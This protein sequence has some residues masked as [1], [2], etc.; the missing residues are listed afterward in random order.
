MKGIES[1][2]NYESSETAHSP[3]PRGYGGRSPPIRTYNAGQWCASDFQR[4]I[5]L[6]L[7]YRY[8]KLA[9]EANF[10]CF[11]KAR[12]ALAITHKPRITF[13]FAC[14]SLDSWKWKQNTPFRYNYNHIRD[15]CRAKN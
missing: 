9:E 13:I 12:R 3:R 6:F 15:F 8:A 1:Q 7:M 4:Y 10:P 5:N 11:G 14:S 2:K